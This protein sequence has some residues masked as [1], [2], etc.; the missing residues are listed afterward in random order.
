MGMNII[1]VKDLRNN[2][3][4]YANRTKKGDSFLVIK[5]SKPLFQLMPIEEE[6]TEEAKGWKT[7]IDF[8]KI[9]KG[10]VS[11]KE[12]IRALEISLKNDK[13]IGQNFKVSK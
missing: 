4:K 1:S 9:R 3:Q 10:G 7:L 2:L 13:K 12:V 11:A 6:T 8:T 5:Q